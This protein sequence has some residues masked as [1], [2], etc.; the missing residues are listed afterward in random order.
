ME[1]CRLA[2]SACP[3]IAGPGAELIFSIDAP[4]LTWLE[5]KAAAFVSLSL[6]MLIRIMLRIIFGAPRGRF[7]WSG[8]LKTFGVRVSI[9]FLVTEPAKS[10][11]TTS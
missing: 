5:A 3:T 11:H 6:C 4:T 10:K 1:A 2:R 9:I 7:S 8:C